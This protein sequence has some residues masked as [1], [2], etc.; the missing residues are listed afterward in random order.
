ML[1]SLTKG[2]LNSATKA[3][4]I[5][6]AT[7]GIRF[8]AVSPGV[9]ATPM[10]PAETHEFLAGL[11]PV[12]RLGQISDV[13]DAIVFQGV[14]PYTIGRAGVTE[15]YAGQPA[16]MTVAYRILQTR[17]LADDVVLG[18]VAAEFSLVDRPPIAVNLTVVARR[19]GGAWRIA[20]YHVSPRIPAEESTPS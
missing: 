4:A 1:A 6:Y 15:Y 17:E 8:N 16:G 10:H 11:H 12:G 5:E 19:A 7:R 2:G 18:W 14:H 9:I 3:L 20:H 13:T